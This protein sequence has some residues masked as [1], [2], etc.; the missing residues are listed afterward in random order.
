MGIARRKSGT[1]VTCPNCAGQVVVPG[2]DDA[3]PAPSAPP[4]P[5]AAGSQKTENEPALF[6]RGDFDDLFRKKAP[7]APVPAPAPPPLQHQPA[8]GTIKAPVTQAPQPTSE[9]FDFNM[10]RPAAVHGIVLTPSMATLLSVALVVA[11]ALAFTA[12]LLVGRFYLESTPKDDPQD[13]SVIQRT[14]DPV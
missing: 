13:S 10:N 8:P 14:I 1:V 6:E 2:E 3:P 5:A 7:T 11:L 12:G 9:R 4:P